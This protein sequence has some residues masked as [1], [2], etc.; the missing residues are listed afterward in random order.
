MCMLEIE[1]VILET[2][3]FL[4]YQSC[5]LFGSVSCF[6]RQAGSGSNTPSLTKS[7]D[8]FLYIHRSDTWIWWLE[9]MVKIPNVMSRWV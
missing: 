1:S 7:T 3:G 5:M 4:S 6:L 9:D 8:T 2:T